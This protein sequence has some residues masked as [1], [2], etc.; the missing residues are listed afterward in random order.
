MNAN[1]TEKQWEEEMHAMQFCGGHSAF[2]SCNL[3]CSSCHEI[4]FYGPREIPNEGRKYRACKWCGFWQEAA[5]SVFN[6]RGG[7]PYRG[8]IISHKN[9]GAENTWG[10]S[11]G[12]K[13]CEKCN[14]DVVEEG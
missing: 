10:T 5:G 2:G 3:E 14:D 4:G 8:T 7:D 11:G 9:C 12:D 6:S 1:H 13:W